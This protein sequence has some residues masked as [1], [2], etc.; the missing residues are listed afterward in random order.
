MRPAISD[1]AVGGGAL[2]VDWMRLSPYGTPGVFESRVHDAGSTTTWSTMTWTDQIPAGTSLTLE[3]RGGNTATP[4]GSWTPFTTV[5][6]SGTDVGLSARY[7]Q[8]RASL[9]S[10]DPAV[11]PALLDVQVVCAEP[12]ASRARSWGSIKQRYR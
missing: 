5:P 1:F 8:Y 4:D 3:V 12:T 11:T 2:G 7:I 6:V 9:A 10:N